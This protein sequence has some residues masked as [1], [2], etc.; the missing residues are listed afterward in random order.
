MLPFSLLY[1]NTFSQN[2]FIDSIVVV[3]AGNCHTCN[4]SAISSHI[5]GEYP[6]YTYRWSNGETS[7]K[8]TDLCAGNYRLHVTDS[9]GDTAGIGFT[10]GPVLSDTINYVNAAC[11]NNTGTA[12]VTV[13]GGIS[14]YTYNWSNGATTSS[15]SGLSAGTYT[16]TI[17]DAEGCSITNTVTIIHALTLTLSITNITCFGYNNGT[18]TVTVISGGVSPY[19]FSWMP[20][21]ETNS[22]ATGLSAGNYLATVTD[23]NGCKGKDSIIISQP[24][25]LQL[26]TI[27]H[28]TANGAYGATCGKSNGTGW[29]PYVTGGTM[30]FTYSWKPAGGTNNIATGLSAGS[31]TVNIT[32]INGCSISGTV[33]VPAIGPVLTIATGDDSCYSQSNGFATVTSVT[34]GI[35]PYTYNWAPP[36]NTTDSI[37]GLSAGN[38][39][40]MVTDNTGCLSTS[41]VT[42]YQPDSIV[43]VIDTIPDTG[44]CSGS[45]T[46]YVKG[47][48]RP[49]K[50]TWSPPINAIVDSNFFFGEEADSLCYGVYQVCVTDINGCSACDSIHIRDARKR[51]LGISRIGGESGGIK[52]YPVPANSDLIIQTNGIADGSYALTVYDLMGKKILCIENEEIS[53]G[54]TISMDVSQIP[55]G[56]YM[57]R[58]NGAN[59]AQ[60]A[61]FIVVH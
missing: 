17:N 31:Y 13:G 24:M 60:R 23:A 33:I 4:G 14:P 26:D 55:Q 28:D 38:Y 57:L 47:G 22:S 35:S 56:D 49:F 10:V 51:A 59:S 18:A 29:V 45:F 41:L 12:S 19:T 48:T 11:S 61:P 52:I 9:H 42:I 2:I 58:I 34:G 30:P 21:G 1:I 8:D 16:I 54:R 46:L 7:Q 44:S 20:S 40:L 50:Y 25:P 43:F 37:G 36:R 5:A 27:H 3:N 53:S 15:V 32:D 6:P 39:T